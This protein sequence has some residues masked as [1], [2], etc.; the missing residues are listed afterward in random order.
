MQL[1]E[2]G[3]ESACRKIA[4]NPDTSEQILV[5][6]TEHEN[7]WVRAGVARNPNTPINLL[8]QLASD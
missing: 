7:K 3:D 1:F 4:R 8:V 5:K 2:M 6:L